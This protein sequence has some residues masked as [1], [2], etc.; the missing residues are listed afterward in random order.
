MLAVAAIVVAIAGPLVGFHRLDAAS[1]AQTRLTDA[2]QDLD[3]LLR[4]QLNEEASLRGFAATGD[5]YF[6]V[7]D[8]PPNPAFGREATALETELRGLG[9]TDTLP[10]VSTLLRTHD[11]WEREVALPLL[12]QPN[13]KD[14]DARQAYGKHLTD[15]L[16]EDAAGIRSRLNAAGD[17]VERQLRRGINTAVGVSVLLIAL[18]AL[19][20]SRLVLMGLRTSERLAHQRVMVDSLQRSLR[21]EGETLP[22]TTMGFTYASATVDALVGGDLLDSWRTDSE[23]GWFLIADASGKGIEAARH[24]AFAQYAIRAIAAEEADPGR[25]LERFNRLFLATFADPGVFVVIFLAAYDAPARHLRYASAG[26]GNAWVRSNGAVRMLAP[27]GSLIG[28]DATERYTAQEVTLGVGD[29]VVLATDGL[30]E[31]RDAAGELFGEDAV[32]AFLASGPQ[33]PQPLCDGL[34]VEAERFTGGAVTDDMAILALRVVQ[35]DTGISAPFDALSAPE[36][37]GTS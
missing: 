3:D 1:V 29:L 6:L 26:H 34:V 22:H 32:S 33:E 15:S 28:L 37:A 31:A 9:F 24:A 19:L 27:T 5:R 20:A 14:A 11:T 18:F 7:P 30:T 4:V 36:S 23:H 17:D 10:V 2:S 16:R 12:T 25:V 8:G 13:G 35:D 21:V